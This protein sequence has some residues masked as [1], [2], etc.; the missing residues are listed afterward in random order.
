MYRTRWIVVV[1]ID[2][3]EDCPNQIFSDIVWGLVDSD[4]RSRDS[5]EACFSWQTDLLLPPFLLYSDVFSNRV[6]H[7]GFLIL[8]LVL[9]PFHSRVI[10]SKFARPLPGEKHPAP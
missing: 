4:S 1:Q 3:S 2:L 8:R 9:L 5:P 7:V 10:G 6:C